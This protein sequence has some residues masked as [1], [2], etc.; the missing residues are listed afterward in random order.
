[1]LQSASSKDPGYHPEVID[2]LNTNA[3]GSGNVEGG[4]VTGRVAK[5]AMLQPTGDKG[6]C[7]R[8]GIVDR[9]EECRVAPRNAE[10]AEV[11]GGG[12]EK[13]RKARR[14]RLPSTVPALLIA[15]SCVEELPGG[16]KVVMLPAA[17]LKNPCGGPLDSEE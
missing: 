11:A 16:S 2:G 9:T 3:L 10:G 4:E 8:P 13:I 5:E 1:M 6:P 12:A 7:D 15:P 17:S 14:V